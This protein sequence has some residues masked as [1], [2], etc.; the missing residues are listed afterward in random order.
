M[1]V[2]QHDSSRKK[3]ITLSQF[4]TAS[5]LKGHSWQNSLSNCVL[6]LDL[7]MQKHVSI[8]SSY[9]FVNERSRGLH[10]QS[11]KEGFSVV[12]VD[13]FVLHEEADSSM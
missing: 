13:V 8:I 10:C 12:V 2:R 4:G 5:C 9:S 11:I 6:E 7:I 1:I 3:N